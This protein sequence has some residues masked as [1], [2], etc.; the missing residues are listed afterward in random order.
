MAA[1][2]VAWSRSSA[3]DAPNGAA[4]RLI[5]LSDQICQPVHGRDALT[6][7]LA[8]ACTMVPGTVCASLTQLTDA[9]PRR[10][11][12]VA[13]SAATAAAVDA[14]EH[15]TGQ[16]P[17]MAAI[18]EATIIACAFTT[19]TRW[20][21]YISRALTAGTVRAVLSYPLT[22]AGH[23]A[24]TLNFYSNS[25]N[26]FQAA[27]EENI[28]LAAAGL[29]LA[30]TAITQTQRAAQL[31]SAL[32]SNRT[33]AAAQGILMH[34]HR[35]TPEQALGALRDASQHSNR[36]MRYIADHVLATNDLPPPSISK[37]RSRCERI[38]P[39]RG[40]AA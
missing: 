34:R 33:I 36:K 2:P 18:A 11:R 16:G 23:P 6:E 21:A 3:V 8:L 38:A 28:H 12:T 30:L 14:I 26:A 7:A 35:W 10:P 25:P 5:R 9:D 31:A 20:P 32:A 37:R 4:A 39:D 1:T 19:E 27:D 22:R 15:Q 17:A 29:A 24:T 13:A 40:D